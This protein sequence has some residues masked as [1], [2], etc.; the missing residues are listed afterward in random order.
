M[1]LVSSTFSFPYLLLQMQSSLVIIAPPPCE[2]SAHSL[3]QLPSQPQPQT[4]HTTHNLCMR[5][6]QGCL[7]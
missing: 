2:L 3:L 6:A 5:R 4:V 1:I 7:P